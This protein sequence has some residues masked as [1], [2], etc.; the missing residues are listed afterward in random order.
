MSS[1]ATSGEAPT[2]ATP[3]ASV[4]E[5]GESAL[6]RPE[7][8]PS[9][10]P[11]Y[12]KRPKRPSDASDDVRSARNSFASDA[13]DPSKTPYDPTVGERILWQKLGGR[14]SP[15]RPVQSTSVVRR[16]ISELL[17]EALRSSAAELSGKAAD[18]T[19]A[20]KE[21]Q[22]RRDRE[23]AMAERAEQATKVRNMWSK[24][25]AVAQVIN[26]LASKRSEAA[27]DPS[28][29]ASTA[30]SLSSAGPLGARASSVQEKIQQTIDETLQQALGEKERK[31]L[32]ET[33]NTL[34]SLR[35]ALA[36]EDEPSLGSS[37]AARASRAKF[38]PR[39]SHRDIALCITLVDKIAPE[40]MKN[41]SQSSQ[42]AVVESITLREYDAGEP[43]FLQNA[44]PDGYYYIVAGEV[45]IYRHLEGSSDKDYDGR[46]G[47][48]HDLYGKRL[49][50]LRREQGF[51]ELSFALAAHERSSGEGTTRSATVVADG[52]AE[53]GVLDVIRTSEAA[54]T[55]SGTA[56]THNDKHGSGAEVSTASVSGGG[57]GEAAGS[58]GGDSGG[59]N[60]S[61]GGGG[62]GGNGGG[63][64][65]RRHPTV[66]L[67]V[68]AHTY[69]LEMSRHTD[70]ELR[71]KMAWLERSLLFQHRPLEGLYEVAQHL[72]ARSV[73]PGK[74]LS[75]TGDSV[76]EVY[77]IESGE[78]IIFKTMTTA[79]ENEQAK[80]YVR[81]ADA[82]ASDRDDSPFVPK[83]ARPKL[84]GAAA[85]GPETAEDDDAAGLVTSSTGAMRRSE[86]AILGA[87][88]VFGI[89]DMMRNKP[90]ATRSAV[91]RAGGD[92]VEMFAI[93]AIA[94]RLHVLSDPHSAELL[95]RLVANRVHWDSLRAQAVRAAPDLAVRVT[96]EMMGLAK[97]TLTPEAL[98]PRAELQQ[99]ARARSEITCAARIARVATSRAAREEASGHLTSAITSLLEAE[100]QCACIEQ[101][102][103]SLSETLGI[104]QPRWA[105]EQAGEARQR[106][107]RLSNEKARI[108]RLRDERQSALERAR[109]Q[110]R[111][112]ARDERIHAGAHG[113]VRGRPPNQTREQL[114]APPSRGDRDSAGTRSSQPPS[115]PDTR[116]NAAAAVSVVS[117]RSRPVM[118]FVLAPRI[119]DPRL[120]RGKHAGRTPRHDSRD[121]TASGDGDHSGS[122]KGHRSQSELVESPPELKAWRA[123]TRERVQHA[124]AVGRVEYFP[125]GIDLDA[126]VRPPPEVREAPFEA[127]D[128]S[129]ID[130]WRVRVS[131][132]SMT[133]SCDA[134][135]LTTGLVACTTTPLV[136]A[137]QRLEASLRGLDPQDWGRRNERRASRR[138]KDM[139]SLPEAKDAAPSPL[140]PH[141][142]SSK[143]PRS[144][145]STTTS[146]SP[147]ETFESR[148]DG[149]PRTS[150]AVSRAIADVGSAHKIMVVDDS[151]LLRK[152]LRSNFARLGYTVDVA[153]CTDEAANMLQERVYDLLLVEHD[154]PGE[155]GLEL[156]EQIRHHE[157]RRR[158]CPF[159]EYRANTQWKQAFVLFLTP[160]Q[161]QQHQQRQQSTSFSPGIGEDTQQ[162]IQ[163]E[164]NHLTSVRQRALELGAVV[165]PK[166]CD[167]TVLVNLA[168][169][170]CG[171]DGWS[172]LEHDA[173]RN[174]PSPLPC[175]V[176]DLS[177]AR[178]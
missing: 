37:E 23:R 150:T 125:E 156:L 22:A 30:A 178:S 16:G 26:T 59:G 3:A 57:G 60:S 47:V 176:S 61:G 164:A 103:G 146:I 80:T 69:V 87:G 79:M 13:H 46:A 15:R 162:A 93:S 70:S 38:Q 142:S 90:R 44:L 20:S 10:P 1:V 139:V 95:S 134:D 110:R 83:H 21:E 9:R 76:E 167:F 159:G 92:P 108:L 45:S 155:S 115:G 91:V 166:T 6:R 161:A 169:S 89:V 137:A 88:E 141:H 138:I 172:S 128:A 31:I 56:N 77:M 73:P 84:L 66:C 123:K 29:G 112:N 119:P 171:P 2:A 49:N 99:L 8:V 163:A 129:T 4:G 160:R 131:A 145:D 96:R 177:A 32:E 63:G 94:F 18:A 158:A 85:A 81:R 58:S 151:P 152:L 40:L 71:R 100:A 5:I 147:H 173:G 78:L 97:Y 27:G 120:T 118:S 65:P 126:D 144:F 106:L 55:G 122:S 121:N 168:V 101:L 24:V 33:T 52:D 154:L 14:R 11:G 72:R 35:R 170:A 25:R 114:S 50:V 109:L 105:V 143:P 104:L 64:G 28:L 157:A 98:L 39:R 43:V 174:T 113:G 62:G 153:S 7:V 67:H 175:L 116:A 74:H 41:L 36:G 51:G 140:P 82:G 86:V 75:H 127:A 136:N 12:S 111:L 102:A 34:Q 165:Q 133:S 68:P 124:L 117:P 42:R 54:V 149:S 107:E 17:S 19:N 132:R 148:T 48:F 130:S 53:L 135:S